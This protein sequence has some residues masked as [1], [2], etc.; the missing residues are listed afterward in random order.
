MSTLLLD[1]AMTSFQQLDKCESVRRNRKTDIFVSRSLPGDNLPRRVHVH[2]QCKTMSEHSLQFFM[3][4]YL[5]R[6]SKAPGFGSPVGDNECGRNHKRWSRIFIMKQERQVLYSFSIYCFLVHCVK[7]SST[8][9]H[10]LESLLSAWP[11][12]KNPFI[13]S[14][15]QLHIQRNS[16][17]LT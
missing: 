5:Q 8:E 14:G 6:W 16:R 12:N 9:C 15:F 4:S 11:Q 1:Y 13:N 17:I 10:N 7:Y 2:C 3:F